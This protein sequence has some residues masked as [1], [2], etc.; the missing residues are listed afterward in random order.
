[1]QALQ[2]PTPHGSLILARFRRDYAPRMPEN[3]VPGTVAG[4]PGQL[5][6]RHIRGIFALAEEEPA[7][8]AGLKVGGYPLDPDSI[9][10]LVARQDGSVQLLVGF[11]G[12]EGA[13]PSLDGMV[14]ISLPEQGLHS[15]FQA[16]LGAFF[17]I[18]AAK[19]APHLSSDCPQVV[20]NLVGAAVKDA[21]ALVGKAAA[22]F[23][24]K[25]REL[26]ANVTAPSSLA[27]RHG[28]IPGMATVPV[29]AARPAPETPED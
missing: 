11:Q 6:A 28:L 2:R 15:I 8:A 19:V 20:G 21:E 12:D 10:V 7:G 24:G 29:R 14:M 23:A 4:E 9:S 5:V 22:T 27:A 3:A 13:N 16:L 17:G 25:L 18:E 1:M 26:E